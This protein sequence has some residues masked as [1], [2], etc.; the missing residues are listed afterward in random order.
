MSRSLRNHPIPLIPLFFLAAA[1]LS[2]RSPIQA[3]NL[4][5]WSAPPAGWDYVYNADADEDEDGEFTGTGGSLDGTWTH[6]NNSDAWD[7]SGPGDATLPDGTPRTTKGGAGILA[8][9]GLAEDGGAASVLAVVDALTAGNNRKMWFC[10][11]VSQDAVDGSRALADGLTLIARYRQIPDQNPAAPGWQLMDGG[12]EDDAAQGV[13]PGYTLRDGGKGGIGFYDVGLGRIFAFCPYGPDGFQFPPQV[14]EGLKPATLLKVGD[15]TIFHSF[16]INIGAGTLADRFTVA[17]YLDGS[18]TPAAVF[19][20]IQLGPNTDCGGISH[21]HMGFHSSPQKGAFEVDYFGF[22]IGTFEPFSECP[23]GFE[24]IFDPATGKVSGSWGAGAAADGFRILRN[25]EVL[26]DNLPAGATS[27]EDP[28]PIRPEATYKLISL[29]GG[30]P[31]PGCNFPQCAVTTVVCPGSLT[32]I[33]DRATGEVTLNWTEGKFIDVT[34]YAIRRDGAD[35]GTAPAGAV[36][37]KDS[38]VPPGEH[39]YELA[40]QTA[41][42]GACASAPFCLARL[43]T[44][45]SPEISGPDWNKAGLNGDVALVTTEDGKLSLFFPDNLSGDCNDRASLILDVAAL[46]GGA[47]QA[48][49]PVELELRY[50]NNLLI[51]NQSLDEPGKLGFDLSR[52]GVSFAQD[53]TGTQEIVA[54]VA[55]PPAPTSTSQISFLVSTVETLL[56]LKLGR[57]VL[58]VTAYYNDLANLADDP[59][60][61]DPPGDPN[62]VDDPMQIFALRLGPFTPGLSAAFVQTPCPSGLGCARD[63]ATGKIALSWRAGAP[64]SY[65]LRRDGAL[66]AA[67]PMGN[68]TSYE[69]ANPGIGFHNYELKA[70]DDASCTATTCV[71]GGGTPDSEGVIREWLVL[72]PLNW[73]CGPIPQDCDDPLLTDIQDD[74]ILGTAGGKPVDQMTIQPVAGMELA[75][76]PRARATG[77]RA[78]AR[79][80]LNPKRPG[81][82]T[83][84]AYQAPGSE[85]DYNRVFGADPGDIYVACAVAYV[86]NTTG[87]P[88]DCD[89]GVWSDDSV[90]VYINEASV[91]ANSVARPLADL[92][93]AHDV[94][95]VT[96]KAGINRV[97]VKVFEGAGGTGFRLRFEESGVGT[98][99]TSGLRVLLAP[100]ELG[101]RFRRGDLDSSGAVDISDPIN[102]LHSLFLGDFT[103]TCQDAAD[104]DDS[105]EVDISDMINSLLWQFASGSA[106]PPPGSF[107]CGVDP[108]ADKTAPDIGCGSYSAACP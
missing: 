34:G 59:C 20:N 108:T 76:D 107:D 51:D 61:A 38:G 55:G 44:P 52:T 35:R 78:T 85:V 97:L 99:I 104:F 43:F 19:E 63:A 36:S 27:F 82:G 23:G 79:P 22:K 47:Q 83:W 5:G 54:Q 88:L 29:S 62:N 7:G 26:L 68:T 90:E 100:G 12:I 96:L 25:G 66:I 3:Q 70:T 69:D 49:V 71:A 81:T 80:E 94:A 39:T 13:V 18:L 102:G 40:A 67:I 8:Y 87:N 4:G 93:A 45:A 50:D 16:W 28:S 92:T 60:E 72:G 46:P 6:N 1:G 42:A 65:E 105:G 2:S 58:E 9:P 10:H 17:V 14:A 84:F 95:P 103:I 33:P 56:P 15:N 86:E 11:D 30:N 32:C 75:L 48:D 64:H 89:L 57:N 73:D 31:R 106:A 77:I 74:F 37:F 53:Q 41:A 101:P 91:W 21:L 98:P 24:C